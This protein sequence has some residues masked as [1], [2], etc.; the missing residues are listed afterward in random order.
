MTKRTGAKARAKPAE[1]RALPFAAFLCALA[2]LTI[3]G[4]VYLQTR[5]FG[6]VRDDEPLNLTQ[7]RL[8]NGPTGI[9]LGAIWTQAYEGL[10]IPLSYS[11]WAL[12]KVLGIAFM[13]PVPPFHASLFHLTSVF[14][15]GVNVLLVF[16]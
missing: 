14:L 8:L 5:T 1:A 11:A 4:V 15:H 7:N 9:H 13:G 16:A 2:L 10:Y 12:L 3:V 6:F